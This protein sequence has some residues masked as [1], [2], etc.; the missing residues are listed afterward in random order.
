M[1]ELSDKELVEKVQ[2]GDI[3]A[4]EKLLF[5]YEKQIFFYILKFINQKEN[6]QDITQETFIKVYRSLKTFDPEYKFKTWLYTIAT[7]TAYD[8]L[9]KAKN[10][11]EIFIIDDPDNNFETIDDRSSYKEIEAKELLEKPMQN[12]KPA[13]KSA[14]LLYYYDGMKYEEIAQILGVP[15]NTVKTYLLRAKAQLKKEIK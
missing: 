14:L 8:W 11:Q 1:T 12:L 15:L 4:F 7:N 3:L 5:R 6:A 9:R 2:S 13:Y 10:N